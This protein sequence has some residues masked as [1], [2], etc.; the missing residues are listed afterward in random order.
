MVSSPSR[1]NDIT[2]ER[3]QAFFLASRGKTHF[4]SGATTSIEVRADTNGLRTM[5]KK[6]FQ[7]GRSERSCEEVHTALRVSRSPI[8]LILVS[9]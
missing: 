4:G 9:G 2:V 1:P 8:E 6:A 5:F 3:Q 7:Q